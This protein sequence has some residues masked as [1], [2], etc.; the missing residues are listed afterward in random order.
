[1]TS[2]PLKYWYHRPYVPESV[3]KLSTCPAF[4]GNDIVET[5]H[6]VAAAAGQSRIQRARRG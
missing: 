3:T 4:S 5:R 6:D 1:M 2:R